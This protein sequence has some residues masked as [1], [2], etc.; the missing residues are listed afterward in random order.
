MDL[1]VVIM[2]RGAWQKLAEPATIESFI[3]NSGELSLLR[4]A[5]IIA[6]VFVVFG[7]SLSIYLL[8]DHLS[9]YNKPE[10]RLYAPRTVNLNFT[11]IFS[12]FIDKMHA[13]EK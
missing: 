8:F 9:S 3:V 10:V 4:W 11:G 6:S 12:P 7:L 5:L 13:S 2:G 1:P